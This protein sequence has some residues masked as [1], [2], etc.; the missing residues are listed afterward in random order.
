MHKPNLTNY[1]IKGTED[2]KAKL[3]LKKICAIIIV[4]IINLV[5]IVTLYKQQ[6]SHLPRNLLRNTQNRTWEKEQHNDATAHQ[7]FTCEEED[8]S[9]QERHFSFIRWGKLDW[10]H[11]GK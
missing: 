8:E 5:I 3:V 11:S 2:W 9:G 4:T 10:L 1:G 6:E 7:L